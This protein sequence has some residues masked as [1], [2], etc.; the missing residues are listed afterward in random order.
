MELSVDRV[1]LVRLALDQLSAVAS[2]KRNVRCAPRK[3]TLE[4][5]RQMSALCEKRTFCAAAKMTL[6]DHLVGAGEQRR[7]HRDTERLRSREIDRELEFSWLLYWQ[8]GRS[9]SA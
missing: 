9:G 3:R 1:H 6:F 8:V 2:R 4:L 5:T 7:C